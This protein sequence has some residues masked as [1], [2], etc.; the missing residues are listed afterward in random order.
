MSIDRSLDRLAAIKAELSKPSTAEA[1]GLKAFKVTK[2]IVLPFGNEEDEIVRQDRIIWAEDEES[3]QAEFV[4]NAPKPIIS[5]DVREIKPTG[6]D[7]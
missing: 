5:W 6:G 4:M 1:E 2:T 3:A 7:A